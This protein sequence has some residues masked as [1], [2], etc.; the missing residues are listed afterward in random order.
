MIIDHQWLITDDHWSSMIDH[1]W[2]LIINDQTLMI[3]DHQWTWMSNICHFL[4]DV[5]FFLYWLGDIIGSFLAISE[6]V[7]VISDVVFNDFFKNGKK[8]AKNAKW[9]RLVSSIEKT[10]ENVL[11][12]KNVQNYMKFG[13]NSG[14]LYIY[15]YIYIYTPDPPHSGQYVK[16]NGKHVPEH[17]ASWAS[18]IKNPA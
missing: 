15:I 9:V 8:I 2:S 5:M 10:L 17:T 3:I 13:Q 1:W 16:W 12:L 18:W 11:D 7:L 14:N 6:V 4:V